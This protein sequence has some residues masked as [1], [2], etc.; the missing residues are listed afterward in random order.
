[1]KGQQFFHTGLYLVA[2]AG[3]THQ[4]RKSPS[5]EKLKPKQPSEHRFLSAQWSPESA[6]STSPLTT[7]DSDSRD[8]KPWGNPQEA[9]PLGFPQ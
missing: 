2:G 6:A 4:K 8:E 9:S 7:E 3:G 1:M 5:T